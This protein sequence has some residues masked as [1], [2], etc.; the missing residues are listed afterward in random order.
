MN[1]G[2]TFN[3]TINKKGNMKSVK[4]ILLEYEKAD[5]YER[6]LLFLA[7][8]DLRDVFMEIELNHAPSQKEKITCR[9]IFYAF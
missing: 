6:T 9:G 3:N 7:H 5:V 8:R 2:K 4:E 1:R